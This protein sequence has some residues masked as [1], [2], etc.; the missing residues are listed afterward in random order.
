VPVLFV[1]V[2]GFGLQ[3]QWYENGV[4]I[5]GATSSSLEVTNESIGKEYY[6][7]V[8]DWLGDSVTSA[9]CTIENVNL[10]FYSITITCGE[11]GRISPNTDFETSEG[12]SISFEVTSDEGYEIDEILVNGQPTSVTG[13][14]F[15]V[16]NITA[17][18]TIEVMFKQTQIPLTAYTIT[19]SVNG[20][21]TT[22]PSG[23]KT[24]NAETDTIITFLANEGYKVEKVLVNGVN[25]GSVNT[26]TVENISANIS[27]VVYF[28][29]SSSAVIEGLLTTEQI[30]IISAC[31]GGAVFILIA[32]KIILSAK[33][34]SKL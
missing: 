14:M 11:N 27:I 28:V 22:N 32:L 5:S 1:E 7:V 25:I 21:G 2:Q 8:T 13:N 3:Y 18:T 29:E 10:T 34:K 31:V 4:E 12:S 23:V 30:I 6:V 26:Y 17:D 19:I 24:V 16:Q 15:T 9:V 33:R 20:Y